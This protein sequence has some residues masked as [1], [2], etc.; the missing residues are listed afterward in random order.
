MKQAPEI[1]EALLNFGLT[2]KQVERVFAT[3]AIGKILGIWPSEDGD[4]VL[5]TTTNRKKFITLKRGDYKEIDPVAREVRA[6]RSKIILTITTKARSSRRRG[7]F[8]EE[9]T[10]SVDLGDWVKNPTKPS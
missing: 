2:R 1:A 7:G 5:L 9:A 4:K 8:S 6:L 3:P 10:S